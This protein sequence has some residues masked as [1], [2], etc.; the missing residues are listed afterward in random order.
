M[1]TFSRPIG[2]NTDAA[3]RR[4]VVSCQLL[5]WASCCLSWLMVAIAVAHYRC[6]LAATQPSPQ[7][8]STKLTYVADDG[9]TGQKQSIE[10]SSERAGSASSINRMEGNCVII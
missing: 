3:K 10:S 9:Q 6:M 2:D 8:F 5:F 7:N 4:L 1:G